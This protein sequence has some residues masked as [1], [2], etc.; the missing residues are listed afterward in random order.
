MGII[1]AD[2]LAASE[3]VD[4]MHGHV[5]TRLPPG[6]GLQEAF[7][8]GE[9]FQAAATWAAAD[10]RRSVFLALWRGHDVPE[11]TGA[12]VGAWSVTADSEDILV[13]HANADEGLLGIQMS[14]LTRAQGDD[15]VA[16]IPT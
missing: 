7:T 16:S 9:G 11:G 10:C 3:L 14:G 6:F 13:Y 4:A 12:K 5:P 1:R 15:I 8:E 2:T